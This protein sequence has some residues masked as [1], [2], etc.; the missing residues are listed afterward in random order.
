MYQVT[1]DRKSTF[2]A[3]SLSPQLENLAIVPHKILSIN[4]YL[5][6]VLSEVHN[7]Y[8]L[9]LDYKPSSKIENIIL[10]YHKQLFGK[11]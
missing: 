4:N 1:N 3:R 9:S 5:Y 11:Y 2:K 8:Q 6:S 10:L 7:Y